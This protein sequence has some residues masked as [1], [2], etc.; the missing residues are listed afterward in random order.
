MRAR[1]RHL[2]LVLCLLVVAAR[3]VAAEPRPV[4]VFAAASTTAPMTEIAERFAAGGTPVRTVFAASST[5]ARQI[6]AGAPADV[7]VSANL[8]WMDDLEARGAIVSATR[9]ERLANRLVLV[10]PADSPLDVTLAPGVGLAARLDGRP[11]AVGDPDHVPSG[12]YARAALVALGEWPALAGR[13]AR[14]ADVR[15]ALALVERGEA[16]AG[17]VYASDARASRRVRVVATFPAST[18]PPIRYAAALVAGRD[19]DAA[20][21]FHAFLA[22]PEADAIFVRHGFTIA[23]GDGE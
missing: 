3:G 21:R 16:A 18:H 9:S 10:A 19:G 20:A 14:S 5:L 4:T 15:A 1:S 8:S 7:Y 11:L 13:L 12:L 6:A 22:S 17:I 23:A 2:G